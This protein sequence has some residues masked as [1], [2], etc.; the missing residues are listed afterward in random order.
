MMVGEETS[1]LLGLGEDASGV[2][3]GGH[4]GN[5]AEGYHESVDSNGQLTFEGAGQGCTAFFKTILAT[6]Q[7]MFF[8]NHISSD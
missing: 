6:C 8:G 7:I 2:I 3:D 1:D 4:V 5:S